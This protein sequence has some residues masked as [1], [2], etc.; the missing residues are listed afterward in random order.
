MLSFLTWKRPGSL[1]CPS[2]YNGSTLPD[3]AFTPTATRI[4][5]QLGVSDSACLLSGICERGHPAPFYRSCP[6]VRE[7]SFSSLISASWSTSESPGHRTRMGCRHSH[8]TLCSRVQTA[9]RQNHWLRVGVRSSSVT[10]SVNVESGNVEPLHGH[11][12]AGTFQV[13]T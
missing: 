2:P 12:R 9:D 8:S 1:I 4:S 11:Q 5:L 13:F 6:S 7:W 3:S 10:V